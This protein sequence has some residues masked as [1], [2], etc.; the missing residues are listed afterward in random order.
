MCFPP[1]T[2][3]RARLLI[4]AGIKV[5]FANV[6]MTQNLH[7]LFDPGGFAPADPHAFACGAPLPRSAPAGAPV[8]R[9]S[10]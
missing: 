5:S 3:E 10:P 4:A 7:D 9:L 8:A 2:V 6:L 1:R